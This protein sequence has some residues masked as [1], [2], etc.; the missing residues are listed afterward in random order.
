MVDMWLRQDLAKFLHL[1][2]P[3]DT[4]QSSRLSEQFSDADKYEKYQKKG[5]GKLGTA[6]ISP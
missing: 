4:I 2:L 3:P 1:L 6:F 5:E